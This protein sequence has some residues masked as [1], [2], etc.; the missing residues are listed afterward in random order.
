MKLKQSIIQT[1][2]GALLMALLT[3]FLVA[4]AVAS[5]LNLVSRQNY[6]VAR[7]HSWNSAIP[8]AEAGIEEA[9][10]HLTDDTNLTANGWVSKTYNG[11][12]VYR[13]DRAVSGG[14][15]YK[16]M[17]DNAGASPVVYSQASI[18]APLGKGSLVR[19]VKVTTTPKT[20]PGPVGI[21]TKQQ[22]NLG[23]DFLIDS[24]N[25]TDPNKSTNGLYDP[26]KAQAHGD[27]ATM[28]A[29]AGQLLLADSKI[30]GHI[31]TTATGGYTGPGTHGMVGDQTFQSDPA[32]QGKIEAGYYSNDLNITIPDVKLPTDG[33]GNPIVFNSLLSV[34][35]IVGGV[36]YAYVFDT[37]NY[38]FP[39]GTT[40]KGKVLVTGTA[41][42]YMPSD[43]RIQFGS[44]DVIN[45]NATGAS[46]ELYNASTTDVVMKDVS[47]SSGIPSRF[48][49]YG[50]PTT[51]GSKLTMT[52]SGALAYAGV[53]NAPNQ[54]M[55][56]TGANS[57]NQ[58]FVGAIIANN[59]TMSGHTYMH[60]DESLFGSGAGAIPVINSYAEISPITF[61]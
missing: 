21:V 27:L 15:S 40:L 3:I 52:G 43:G 6:S 20:I 42:V 50:L 25:S 55:V 36:L 51:A 57:G 5:G 32:N 37:G 24:Y 17:I 11:G 28:S 23:S 4:I 2:G 18:P 12:T 30:F 39:S 44:G 46:L 8:V 19:T 53:I 9:L 56:L 54:N 58:D 10:T 16:V 47:N 49:Y 48:T 26:K 7:A 61:P 34:N 1:T 33:N 22:I 59:F 14:G 38:Q 31:Y 29:S 13:K 45:I 41:R 35:Q 60:I